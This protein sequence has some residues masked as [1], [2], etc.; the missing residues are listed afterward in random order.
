M[1][2]W[3][4]NSDNPSMKAQSSSSNDDEL[5]LTWQHDPLASYPE[6][7]DDGMAMARENEGSAGS[8]RKRS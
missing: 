7:P 5:H 8:A 4:E 2:D 6:E 1:S 3:Y